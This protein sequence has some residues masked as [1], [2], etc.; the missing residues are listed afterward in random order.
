MGAQLMSNNLNQKKW[1]GFKDRNIHFFK[2]PYPW[3]YD[4]KKSLKLLELSF[5]K[6]KEKIDIK[7]DLCGAMLETFQGWGAVYY[8]RS[9]VQKFVKICRQNNIVV[10]FDEIQSGL[11]EQVIILVM[12]IIR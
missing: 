9:F 4:D 1:I 6:L 2:F 7:K 11:R 5:K 3:I 10:A 8:P 12:N